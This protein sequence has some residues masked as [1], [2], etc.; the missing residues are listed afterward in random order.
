M[1]P[2]LSQFPQ[3]NQEQIPS[4]DA[5]RTNAHGAQKKTPDFN[6]GTN[7]YERKPREQKPQKQK[8]R[9]QKPCERKPRE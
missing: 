2:P 9:E 4:D 1:N 3:I 6:L 7:A 8:S 5:L